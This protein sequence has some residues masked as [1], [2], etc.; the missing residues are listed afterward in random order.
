MTNCDFHFHSE[1]RGC[2]SG[3]IYSQ[4][5][6]FQRDLAVINPPN[7][8]QQ[9]DCGAGRVS[10]NLTKTDSGWNKEFLDFLG[11]DRQLWQPLDGQSVSLVIDPKCIGGRALKVNGGS[12]AKFFVQ[13]AQISDDNIAIEH[14]FP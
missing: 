6:Q 2:S 7:Q 11:S 9:P 3:G 5:P 14:F 8:M 10:T 1:E 4:H 13:L 12:V